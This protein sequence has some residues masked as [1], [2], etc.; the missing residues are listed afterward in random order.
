ML[1]ENGAKNGRAGGQASPCGC[2]WRV[3]EQ[4]MSSHEDVVVN[5]H[6]L[7][8][9]P[10]SDCGYKLAQRDVRAPHSATETACPPDVMLETPPG[11]L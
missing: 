3:I 9:R 1:A 11:A 4:S 10:V 5:Q 8:E 7:Y 6:A 2:G